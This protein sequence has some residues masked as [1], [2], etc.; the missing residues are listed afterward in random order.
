LYMS[1]WGGTRAESDPG[2]EPDAWWLM[3]FGEVV[4]ESQEFS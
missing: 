1:C 2:I 3:G 4:D